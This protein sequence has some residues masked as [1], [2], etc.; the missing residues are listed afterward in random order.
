MALKTTVTVTC[1]HCG[2]NIYHDVN[3][4]KARPEEV[5]SFVNPVKRGPVVSIK[6]PYV[7]CEQCEEKLFPEGVG[8]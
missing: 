1:D 8:E 2:R 6:P 4:Y 7:I 3:T 5:H